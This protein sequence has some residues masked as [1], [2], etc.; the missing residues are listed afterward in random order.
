MHTFRLVFTVRIIFSCCIS[1]WRWCWR[2]VE[3]FQFLN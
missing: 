3:T 1:V 2:T